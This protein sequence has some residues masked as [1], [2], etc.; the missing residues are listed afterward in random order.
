MYVSRVDLRRRRNRRVM[1]SHGAILSVDLEGVYRNVDLRRRECFYGERRGNR[2]RRSK[3]AER[4]EERR[5]KSPGKLG[6]FAPFFCLCFLC[7]LLVCER[8]KVIGPTKGLF[9]LKRSSWIPE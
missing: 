2:D 1:L 9:I 8:E 6:I 5:A 4:R 3:S 7:F